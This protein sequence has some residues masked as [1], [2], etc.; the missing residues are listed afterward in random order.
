VADERFA[1]A[2]GFT[3]SAA[4]RPAGEAGRASL[5]TLAIGAARNG[6]RGFGASRASRAAAICRAAT[7]SVAATHRTCAAQIKRRTRAG[8]SLARDSATRATS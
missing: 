7:A 5:G 4:H 3:E 8:F 1:R 6:G 2:A